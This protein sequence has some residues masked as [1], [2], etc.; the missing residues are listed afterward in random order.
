MRTAA[1]ASPRGGAGKTIGGQCPV[2]AQER[3]ARDQDRQRAVQADRAQGF[4]PLA[5]VAALQPGTVRSRLS[6]P[7]VGEEGIAPDIAV[8]K[9]LQ[10]IDGLQPAGRAHFV[11]HEGQVI[12]W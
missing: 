1:P 10:V 4:R 6:Q 5:V 8:R 12:P 3:D 7:F 11:D 9:L 2:C